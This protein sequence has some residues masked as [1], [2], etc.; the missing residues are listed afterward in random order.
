MIRPRTASSDVHLA[1]LQSM[2]CFRS[3]NIV[4]ISFLFR[5][6]CVKSSPF[7][8]HIIISRQTTTVLNRKLKVFETN[9]KHGFQL[10]LVLRRY[11]AEK[12]P[13]LSPV[14][15]RFKKNDSEFNHRRVS[16]CQTR[17]QSHMTKT[18]PKRNNL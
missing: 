11:I 18:C 6:L 8:R 17:V 12:S 10:V 2:P 1:G 9:K 16:K 15:G 13:Y 5:Y 4:S 14:T 7:A 3:L